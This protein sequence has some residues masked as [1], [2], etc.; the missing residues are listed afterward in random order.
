MGSVPVAAQYE[1]QVDVNAV[2]VPVTVRNKAGRVV[3]GVAPKRF[4]AASN[5]RGNSDLRL[6]SES[7]WI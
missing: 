3:T 6:P 2:V 7:D 1:G 4:N 5:E